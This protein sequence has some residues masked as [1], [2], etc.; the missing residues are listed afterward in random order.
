ME[1][2]T[3]IEIAAPAERVWEVLTDFAAYPQWNPFIRWATG[4]ARPGGRLKVHLRPSGARGMTFRPRVLRTA[5]NE[6]LR[7]LGRLGLPGLFDGEH[8]FLLEPLARDR[9]RFVQRERFTGVLV[10][11]LARSLD[12]DTRRGFEEMNA[13]LKLRAEGPRQRDTTGGEAPREGAA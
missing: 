11:L 10:P 9:V 5:P 1:L 12:R 2:R 13:A 7:W 3:E 6:E 8:A 4:E